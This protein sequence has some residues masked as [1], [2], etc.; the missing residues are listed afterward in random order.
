MWLSVQHV[1]VSLRLNT[2]SISV[3]LDINRNAKERETG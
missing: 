3:D 2:C 1:E